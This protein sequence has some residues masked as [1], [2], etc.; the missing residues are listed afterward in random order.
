M[1]CGC[2]GTRSNTFKADMAFTPA[3][4]EACRRLVEMALQEDLGEAGDVTSQAVISADYQGQAVVVARAPGV[5]AGLEAAQ[6][7]FAAVDASLRFEALL[8]DGAKLTPAA[9]LANVSG[10]MRSILAGERTA[11]NFVQHL[12]GVATRTRQFVDAIAGLSCWILDT[13]KTLPGWRALE[14]Y[15]VR[16]GGG[17]NHRIGLYDG[18]L[19]KDNHLAAL[20]IADCGLR[21]QE[22]VR[23]A[24]S[25]HPSMPVEIEVEDLDQFDA[26]LACG[27]DLILL[28]NLSVEQM[29][30][31]VARR[32]AGKKP[33]LL[34]A[35]GGVTL[36]TVRAIAAT[37]VDRISVGAITHSATAL[38]IALDYVS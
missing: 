34:E 35:S 14:K 3:E 30:Q 11:L 13:R 18:I 32:D 20:R 1:E 8:S 33:V 10:S 27:A 5:L 6:I 16:C 24:R 22:A 4:T 15:A 23:R 21:I 12:S 7:V 28:D 36:E 25:F 37:G 26:A 38:D 19:I 17:Y 31:A 29:R 2:S 9:R